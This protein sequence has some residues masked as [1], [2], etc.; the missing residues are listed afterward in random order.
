MHVQDD[1]VKKKVLKSK[2]L[3]VSN[4]LGWDAQTVLYVQNGLFYVLLDSIGV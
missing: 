2:G 4:P 3:H 1:Y